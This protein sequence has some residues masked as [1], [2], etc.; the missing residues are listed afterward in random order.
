M[1]AIRDLHPARFDAM[2]RSE[3]LLTNLHAAADMPPALYLDRLTLG[4]KRVL[5]Y[6]L[7]TALPVPR[8]VWRVLRRT[9]RGTRSILL[10]LSG[11]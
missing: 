6:Q 8:G 3:R 5:I 4:N 10:R 7:L 11:R 2:D 1:E 9:A